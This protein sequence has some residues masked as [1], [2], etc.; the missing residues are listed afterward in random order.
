MLIHKTCIMKSN[1]AKS[2]RRY[3]M[4][5]NTHPI[6]TTD[7]LL[8]IVIHIHF[9]CPK[10][11]KREKPRSDESYD[12]RYLATTGVKSNGSTSANEQARE[13]TISTL[14]RHFRVTSAHSIPFKDALTHLAASIFP[15][16]ADYTRV[17]PYTFFTEF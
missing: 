2:R 9:D 14:G 13:V 12:T 6:C 5:T 16:H 15:T 11:I 10:D 17:V 4:R 7:N 1:D 8:K 3:Y